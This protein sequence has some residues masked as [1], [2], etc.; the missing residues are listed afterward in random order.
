MPERAFPQTYASTLNKVDRSLVCMFSCSHLKTTR[1]L[2]ADTGLSNV[3]TTEPC[4]ESK[5][6]LTRLK[7]FVLTIQDRSRTKG[8]NTVEITRMDGEIE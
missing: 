3:N 1:I 7:V 4:K 2:Y 8:D 5:F 6:S